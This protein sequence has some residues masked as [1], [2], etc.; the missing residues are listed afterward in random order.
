MALALLRGVGAIGA[1][2][3]LRAAGRTS[4]ALAYALLRPRA[5]PDRL[6]RCAHFGSRALCTSASSSAAASAARLQRVA[7]LAQRHA[8]VSGELE[9]CTDFSSAA[10]IGLAQEAGRLEPIGRAHE[11]LLAKRAELS[12]LG[13]LMQEKGD[14]DIRQLALEEAR[15]AEE[16]LAELEAAAVRALAEL[17]AASTPEDELSAA[18]LEVRA[19]AG[20]DEAALFAR[21]LFGM[22]SLYAQQRS[23]AVELM[24]MSEAPSGGLREASMVVRGRGALSGLLSEAGVHRVQRVPVTEKLG[25]VHTSTASVA[26]LPEA[27]EADVVL[28]D[29]ELRIETTRASG[30]GG[31][32]VNTTDSAVRI[33]HL[34]TGL[35]AQCQDERSQQMNKQKALRVLRSR[36]LAHER[37]KLATERSSSRRE[38][39]GANSRSER[40]R[41]Y[42]FHD[43]RI[44]DHRCGLTRHGI[45]RMFRG[46]LLGEFAAALRQA[47]REGAEREGVEAGEG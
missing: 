1:R 4:G 30:A 38:Q 39:I 37:E 21:E 27:E 47:E 10:Y 33:V 25:R 20:G 18:V 19:G 42:N 31:Q 28:A 45:D 6:L 15:E 43:N 16:D 9:R 29:A 14:A 23:W 5:P 2:C 44:T 3:R 11:Q 24:G 7:T 40:I 35:V 8:D 32:H 22:Y 34:P 13:Q 12:E 46:E 41:T 17:D 36:I 26:V